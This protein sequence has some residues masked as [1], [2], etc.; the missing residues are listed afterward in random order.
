MAHPIQD[1]TSRWRNNPDAS[2]TAAL[3]EALRGQPEASLVEEVGQYASG[4]YPADAAVLTAAARMYMAAQRLGEAQTVLVAA[5]KAAPR[6]SL[7]YR[8]LGEVLLRRGDAERSIKV[9]ERVLL[10]GGADPETRLWA[11]RAKVF[12]PMQASAG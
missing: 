3:C 7:V 12:R 6:D 9:L 4:K 10:F 5:G 2:T 11:E 1:L 8:L